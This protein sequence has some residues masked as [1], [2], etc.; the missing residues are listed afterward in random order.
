MSIMVRIVAVKID[1]SN[2]FLE[3]VLCTFFPLL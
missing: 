1:V 2:T 3:V